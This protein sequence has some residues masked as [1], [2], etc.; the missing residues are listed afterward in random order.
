MT[1]NQDQERADMEAARDAEYPLTDS[2]HTSVIQRNEDRREAFADGWQAARRAPSAAPA[3]D[4]AE[5]SNKVRAMPV[6]A[7][8]GTFANGYKSARDLAADHIASLAAP[9]APAASMYV[10]MNLNKKCSPTLTQCPRCNNPWNACDKGAS[11]PAAEVPDTQGMLAGLLKVYAWMEELP[12]P[13][14]GII[15]TMK[16]LRGVIHQL[17]SAAPAGSA[18]AGKEDLPIPHTYGGFSAVFYCANKRQPTGQEAFDA[19]MRSGRDIWGSKAAADGAGEL[20]PEYEPINWKNPATDGNPAEE[21]LYMAIYKGDGKSLPVGL[22]VY[23]AYDFDDDDDEEGDAQVKGIG[24]TESTEDRDGSSWTYIR[25][26]LAYW[27]VNL[28]MKSL[29][30]VRAAI[31]ANKEMP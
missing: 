28:D 21:G 6:P 13:Q 19:G 22:L 10:P 29:K 2:P 17:E 23:G 20:P 16:R 9:S 4:F 15:Q 3:V 8:H 5:I 7:G 27:P 31:R 1:T 30:Q 26:V 14:T 25:E 24:W 18:Q 11:T 12:V